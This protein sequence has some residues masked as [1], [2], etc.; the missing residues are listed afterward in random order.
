MSV[1]AEWQRVL[2]V[3][4]ALER[5]GAL[6]WAGRVCRSLGV[7]LDDVLGMSRSQSLV[8]A[9]HELWSL[10]ADTLALSTPEMGALFNVDHST[11]ISAV[12]NYRARRDIS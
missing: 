11:I 2:R 3:R 1:A 6:E 12:R 9:R 10:V 5:R 7:E 8:R 4:G